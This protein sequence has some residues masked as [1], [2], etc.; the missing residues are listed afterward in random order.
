MKNKQQNIIF[1]FL[2]ALFSAARG[3]DPTSGYVIKSENMQFTDR[4]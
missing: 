2:S 4:C 1:I 3:Y